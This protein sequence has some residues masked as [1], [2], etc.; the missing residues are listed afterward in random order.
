MRKQ[1]PGQPLGFRYF[2]LAGE[3]DIRERHRAQGA[4]TDNRV[5]FSLSDAR[6]VTQ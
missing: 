6:R 4:G 5:V 2:H 1:Y 3:N